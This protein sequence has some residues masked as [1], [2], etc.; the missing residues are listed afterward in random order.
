MGGV[1][2]AVLIFAVLFLDRG[3]VVATMH[4]HKLLPQPERF[5]ELYLEDHLNLPKTYDPRGRNDFA[6]TVHN[7]E[8]EPMTYEYAVHAES[9]ESARI[10][11]TGS[12]TLE[13]DTYK[14]IREQIATSDA[15][16]RTKVSISLENIDQSIHFWVDRSDK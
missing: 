1:V 14:T 11:D 16:L 15:Q 4:R 7:L 12:F 5:T 9:T 3:W 8:H 13:H 2:V 10:I 6:F